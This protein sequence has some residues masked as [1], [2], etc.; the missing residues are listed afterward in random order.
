MAV[1]PTSFGK[2]IFNESFVILKD[3]TDPNQTPSVMV[4]VPCRIITEDQLRSND[5]LRV[6]AF[7]KKGNLLKDMASN[8]Y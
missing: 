5:Y 2:T 6:V 4:I 7:E 1:L 3:T 8:K